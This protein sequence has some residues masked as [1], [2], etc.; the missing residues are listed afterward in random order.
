M[1]NLVTCVPYFGWREYKSRFLTLFG[2][3]LVPPSILSS[4]LPHCT[5]GLTHS[6][7]VVYIDSPEVF[8]SS[9]LYFDPSMTDILPLLYMPCLWL[10]WWFWQLVLVTKIA[11]M[12][13]GKNFLIS[14]FLYVAWLSWCH[15]FIRH[16]SIMVSLKKIL[17]P[18][19]SS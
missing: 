12:L 19:S 11:P 8:V 6:E 7:E 15:Q 10:P 13:W 5:N 17:R 3:C 4:C 9:I 14:H 2:I 16:I 18:R 1:H